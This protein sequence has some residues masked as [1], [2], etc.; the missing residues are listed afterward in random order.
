MRSKNHVQEKFE[1]DSIRMNKLV[2][3]LLARLFELRSDN[4]TKI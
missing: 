4:A 3:L 2:L 1:K